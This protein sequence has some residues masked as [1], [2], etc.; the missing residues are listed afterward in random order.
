MNLNISAFVENLAAKLY[1]DIF[2]FGIW[3][4]IKTTFLLDLIITQINQNL[5]NAK[6]VYQ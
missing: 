6:N 5:I 2:W 4:S 1:A 3:P